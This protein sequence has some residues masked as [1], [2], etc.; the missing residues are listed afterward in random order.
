MRYRRM[1]PKAKQINGPACEVGHLAVVFEEED[2]V[3]LLKEAIEREGGLL[4]S[5]IRSIVLA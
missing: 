4:R 2:L 5:A 3:C 1:P